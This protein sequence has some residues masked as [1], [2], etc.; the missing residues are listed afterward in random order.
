M[1][2]LLAI[3]DDPVQLRLWKKVLDE[4]KYSVALAQN[5]S[6]GLRLMRRERPLVVLCDIKLG[7]TDGLVLLRKLKQIDRDAG[8][9]I[10]TG[11]GSPENLGGARE[12]GVHHFL[13]KPVALG[14]LLQAVRSLAYEKQLERT[15]ARLRLCHTVPC[16]FGSCLLKGE[17]SCPSPDC[18]YAKF[19][20]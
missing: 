1:M 3:D 4:R 15:R 10:I 7:E 12:L 13:E 19:P 5:G 17:D 11:Y 20:S 16:P 9:I 6:Q 2:K 8:F 18:P 14:H